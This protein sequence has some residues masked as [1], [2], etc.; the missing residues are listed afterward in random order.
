MCKQINLTLYDKMTPKKVQDMYKEN[1]STL[2]MIGIPKEYVDAKNMDYIMSFMETF[3]QE[4]LC[5]KMTWNLSFN[6]YDNDP[7]E[8]YEIPE[9]VSYL[10]TVFE[11]AP[12]ITSFLC[13][14]IR[15]LPLMCYSIIKINTK[16]S[17]NTNVGLNPDKVMDF[18]EKSSYGMDQVPYLTDE[19]K[20]QFLFEF[21]ETLNL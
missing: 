6:G 10:N 5:K 16:N 3:K 8:L 18:F 14:E 21:R 20:K 17:S 2:I 15:F 9:V 1:G 13:K 12:W 7:R 11:K 19:D 4:P